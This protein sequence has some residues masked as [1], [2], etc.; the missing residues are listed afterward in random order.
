MFFYLVLESSFREIDSNIDPSLTTSPIV[1]VIPSR[2]YQFRVTAENWLGRGETS[3]VTTV[4]HIPE[5]RKCGRD[6]ES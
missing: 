4:L 6:K 2:S 5:E 1:G 3:D